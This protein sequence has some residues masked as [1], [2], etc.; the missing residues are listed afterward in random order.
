MTENVEKLVELLISIDATTVMEDGALFDNI[1]YLVNHLDVLQSGMSPYDHYLSHGKDERRAFRIVEQVESHL[2]KSENDQ[3]KFFSTKFDMIQSL[4][5]EIDNRNGAAIEFGVFSGSTLKVIRDNFSG[6]VFGFDSFNGLPEDWRE[7]FPKGAFA[8]QQIPVIDGTIIVV[9]VFEDTL[10]RFLEIFT[11]KVSLVHFD[12]DLYSSTKLCLDEVKNHLADDC[13][14]IF[15]EYH[16]YSGWE[17]HEHKAFVEWLTSNPSFLA[18]EVGVVT[19]GNREQK[20]FRI[21]RLSGQE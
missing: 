11:G 2:P 21:R 4:T 6:L 13:I 7:G 9:G 18:M 16:N 10:S 15:D 5:K 14:F 8:T 19:G 17:L 20:A 1:H 12:A 3:L